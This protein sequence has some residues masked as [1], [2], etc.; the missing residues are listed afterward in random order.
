MSLLWLVGAC[1]AAPPTEVWFVDGAVRHV[2][3]GGGPVGSVELPDND[4][5]G[6]SPSG[7]RIALW[8]PDATSVVGAD[9]GGAREVP[10]RFLS[11]P[12]DDHVLTL[13]AG[14]IV[15]TDL[16]TGAGAVVAAITEPLHRDSVPQQTA[17]GGLL[18][19]TTRLQRLD[20]GGSL[21]ELPIPSLLVR[22]GPGGL[23]LGTAG[24]MTGVWRT[25][26]E[27][28]DNLPIAFGAAWRDA[29]HVLLFRPGRVGA[30]GAFDGPMALVEVDVRTT[31]ERLLVAGLPIQDEVFA[32]PGCLIEAGAA[33]VTYGP[34]AASVVRLDLT[35]DVVKTT[36]LYTSSRPPS[37]RTAPVGHLM[38]G[39]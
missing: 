29:E 12:D 19:A 27:L 32:F 37:P 24:G 23:W 13:S 17:D 16:A 2:S 38:C 11:F 28:V 15:R 35:A 4:L 8:D 20:P 10:G 25:D 33:L 14:S 39:R 21:H 5:A 7:K 30:G 9:G 18:F 31:A 1:A 26:G 3:A 22:E 6:V 34:G 36:T